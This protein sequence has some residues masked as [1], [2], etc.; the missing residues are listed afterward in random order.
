MKK[1]RPLSVCAKIAS[2]GRKV[3]YSAAAAA[4][5]VAG[6]GEAEAV[7]VYSGVQDIS[8]NLGFSQS[9]NLDGDAFND[10]QLR[11]SVYFGGNY[12]G[13]T[14]LFGPGK[15][16]GFTSGNAYVSALS[17]GAAIDSSSVGPTFFGSLAYGANNPN[18]Q[19]NSAANTF[20]GLSFPSGGDTLYGWVRVSIDNAAGSFVIHDWAYTDSPDG[21]LAGQTVAA[22][23]EAA[24]LGFFAAG[25]IG[26][27]AMRR[28]RT[29]N[30]ETAA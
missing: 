19:F 10:I 5:V 20:I 3:A 17:A 11:N 24:T 1:C 13:A 16:V 2:P 15:I 9:I 26:L 25:A 4:T 29:Q 27:T 6:A 23:P 22:I 18:A 21:I 7:L 14:V 8:V 28:R 30:E 12:Q